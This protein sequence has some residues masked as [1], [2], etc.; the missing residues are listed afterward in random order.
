MKEISALHHF[1][2]FLLILGYWREGF[3]L[4]QLT[5]VFSFGFM[6]ILLT[7]TGIYFKFI[8]FLGFFFSALCTIKYGFGDFTKF[9]P[10]GPYRVGLKDFISK[11]L[12]NSCSIFYPASDDKSGI[13]GT[14][15][16]FYD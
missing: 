9:K 8:F 14:P 16:L 3:R 5:F 1:I 15:F 6:Y 12:E 11:D 7:L 4:P 2:I 10:S 13:F